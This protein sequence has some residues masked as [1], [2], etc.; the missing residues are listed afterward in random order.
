MVQ[1]IQRAVAGLI[2]SAIALPVV[3]SLAT[4]SAK[5]RPWRLSRKM[6]TVSAGSCVASLMVL[7]AIG[8]AISASPWWLTVPKKPHSGFWVCG[9]L[10]LVISAA[11]SWRGLSPARDG[12]F[13][14]GRGTAKSD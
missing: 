9:M 14:L 3:S 1:P 10:V 13:A 5:W 7:M 4:S 11:P 12:H 2:A 6:A 8:Q